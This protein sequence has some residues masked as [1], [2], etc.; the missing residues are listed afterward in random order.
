V[1]AILR[2]GEKIIFNKKKKRDALRWFEE[3]E[4][5]GYWK[6]SEA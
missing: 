6:D 2:L 4:G 3:T 1:V 5:K